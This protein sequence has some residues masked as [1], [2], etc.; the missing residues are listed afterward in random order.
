MISLHLLEFNFGQKRVVLP[1]R[2]CT[3]SYGR[4]SFPSV[5]SR[6]CIKTAKWIELV[7]G[8]EASL[9]LFYAVFKGN[10]G[11]S[12]NKGTPPWNFVPNSGLGKILQL[13]VDYRKCCQ[14]RWTLSVIN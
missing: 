10:L 12:E 9:G 4:M 7:F 14:L 6:Y 3:I 11:I 13:Y 2:C 5:T 1:A 8:I